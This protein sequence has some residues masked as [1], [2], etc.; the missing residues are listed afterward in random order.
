MTD[1]QSAILHAARPTPISAYTAALI[2]RSAEYLDLLS[3]GHPAGV[4][5]CSPASVQ[6]NYSRSY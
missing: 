2:A 3:S 4:V 1:D 6:P 5:S